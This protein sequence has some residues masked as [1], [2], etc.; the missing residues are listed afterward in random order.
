RRQGRELVD[1]ADGLACEH[2]QHL[3]FEGGVTERHSRQMCKIDRTIIGGERRRWHPFDP[4]G[5]KR[6]AGKAGVLFPVADGAGST[7]QTQ[8]WLRERLTY[9]PTLRL[10]FGQESP[11][12]AGSRKK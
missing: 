10:V 1:Q 2:A 12:S 8:R 9:P 11:Q 6:H 5:V 4:L 7:S 3:A